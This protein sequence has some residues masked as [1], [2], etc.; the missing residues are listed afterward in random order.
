MAT[1]TIGNA[2]TTEDLGVVTNSTVTVGNG[3]D[4]LTFDP[5]S[6]GDTITIGEGNDTINAAGLTASSLTIGNGDDTITIGSNDTLTAGNGVDTITAGSND[7]IS[8]GNG[9]GVGDTI[10]AG[11]NDLIEI[12]NGNNHISAGANTTITPSKNNDNGDNTIDVGAKSTVTVGNGDNAINAGTSNTITIGNG[13]NTI[14]YGG[15]TPRFTVPTSLTVFED[16]PADFPGTTVADTAVSTVALPITIGAPALGNE[17]INGFNPSRD[18]IELDTG[19]F[20]NF[21]TVMADA[22]QVGAN[23]VITLDPGDTITL[24]GV[25]KSSLTASNFTFFN[26][27][28]ADVITITGVPDGSTLSAGTNNGGGKW[29]LTDAQL[30]GLHLIAGEPTTTN[31]PAT[32]TVTV[33]NPAAQAAQSVSTSET[34]ALTINPVPPNVGASVIGDVAG[35]TKLQVSSEVDDLEAVAGNDFINRI[36][37]SVP[38]G[39][40]AGVT[41]STPTTIPTSGHPGTFSTEVDVS[42]PNGAFFT[43]GITAFSDETSGTSGPTPEVSSSTTKVIDIPHVMPDSVT[44]LEDVPIT[45]PISALAS[46]ANPAANLKVTGFTTPPF[47]AVTI[48]PDGQSLTYDPGALFP[49]DFVPG[50]DQVS[51]GFTVTNALGGTNSSTITATEI[52]VADT[53]SVS[54]QVLAPHPGDPANLTRLGV[55]AESADFPTLNTGSDFIQSLGLNLTGTDTSGFTIT[56]NGLSGT[57]ITTTG[58]PGH[59]TDEIDVL[60]PSGTTFN[61]NLAITAVNAETESPSTTASAT[62]NQSIAIDFAAQTQDLNFSTTKQS[63][64]DTG[65]AFTK[66]FSTGFLGVDKSAHGSTSLTA[67]GAKIASAGGSIHFKAGIQAGL[68]ITAGDIS[69]TLPFEVGLDETY[70]KTTDTLEIV[71]SE[72]QLGGGK[73][74]EHGPGGSASFSL[75]LGLHA[76]GHATLAG[77]GPSFN[78]G[79]IGSFTS[80]IFSKTFKSSTVAVPIPLPAG[81]TLTLAFPTVN[82]NSMSAPPGGPI[83]G[84]DH[85]QDF[86]NLAGDL[87]A[88][89]S[90]I[91]SPSHTDIT[92][93]SFGP[94]SVDLLDILIGA[95]LNLV[96]GF[97]VS[98]SGLTPTLTLGTHNDTIP[99]SLTSDTTITNVSSHGLNANGTVPL[100]VA[101]TPNAS[102]ENTTSIGANLTAELQALGLSIGPIG[103]K[104]VDIKTNLQLG[105]FPPLFNKTFPLLGFNTQNVTATV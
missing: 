84:T 96:Q 66:T 103:F 52:P 77:T 75:F 2:N 13:E 98:S 65:N 101:L 46:D 25:A 48:A 94:L 74:T 72:A 36:M 30:A 47:G 95:G 100:S 70:N 32:L 15:L 1:I 20:A 49:L 22:S 17:V 80:P 88:I 71:P 43:L 59:F 12:G 64:W 39:V 92:D 58:D 26:G 86:I 37:L 81:L 67:F 28:A 104:V 50:K 10:T 38:G 33:T 53:P 7:T 90:I 60:A 87:V 27:A 45:I 79:T 54:V 51:F 4:S 78:T 31:T 82:V 73:F 5:G 89:A 97:D 16:H 91:F 40:P 83:S 42:A 41:L 57:T 99:F 85:S 14:T 29:T 105:T 44:T 69:A 24:T 19:D 63:I 18:E 56:A 21:A 35:E 55:L 61:D 11:S 76:T 102:L 9:N 68:H 62:A 34:I 3:D 93:L 8:V 6:T 23:T